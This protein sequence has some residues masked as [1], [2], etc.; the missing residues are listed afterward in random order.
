MA[1]SY[2]S[3][4]RIEEFL[5][6]DEKPPVASLPSERGSTEEDEK[7]SGGSDIPQL[8]SDDEKT[9]VT[10]E[11]SI[12]IAM[13]SA[14]FSWAPDSDAFLQELNLSLTEERLYMCVGPVASVSLHSLRQKY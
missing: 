4:K 3:L 12:A 10:E 7:D 5:L 8:T 14:S 6:K 11:L 9:R 1:A 2:A 13:D